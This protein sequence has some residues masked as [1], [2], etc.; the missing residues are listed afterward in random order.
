MNPPYEQDLASSVSS[1][2]SESVLRDL[3]KRVNREQFETWFRGF[4]VL[5]LDDAEV[6]VSVPNGFLRDWIARNYTDAVSKAV[7]VAKGDQR[8]RRVVVT[9]SVDG[10][11]TAD[12]FA[13]NRLPLDPVEEPTLVSPLSPAPSAPVPNASEMP[14]P[15]F[16]IAP[17]RSTRGTNPASGELSLNESY[18]F[19]EFVVGTSN[20]LAHA[21]AL[22]IGANPGR[23]F[24]PFFVQ[25]AVG[26]GKTHLLQAI[27]HAILRSHPRARV[28]YL[29]C[30][31]F[32]NRFIDSIQN[33]TISQFR[34]YHRSADVLVIDDVEFL[35]HKSQTQEEFFH[36]FNALYN[37]HKQIVL[38]S[39]CPPP[40]I[41][42][43]EA[44]LISRFKWGLETDITPPCFET[45]AAIV[46]RKARMRSIELPSDVVHYLAESVS[47]NIRELE[48][49]V[50]KV[51]G[52]A[53]ITGAP[54]TRA[55][56]EEALREGSV[57]RYRKITMADIMELITTEFSISARDLTSKSRTQAISLP[58]Q[59]G[60]F[61]ARN[62]TE[63]SLEEVGRFFGN[64][65]H[66]TVLYAVGKIKTRSETD[67]M[68]SELLG[69]LGQRLHSGNLERTPAGKA[70]RAAH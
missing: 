44:R 68:F 47:T 22:A 28:I 67:R 11:A 26:L 43:L 14:P 16:A 4:Q 70:R 62:Y 36:T 24:N 57:M 55:L 6:I 32:T 65:D 53:T 1:Q 8:Q 46:R 63:H 35:A 34:E 2:F 60:M 15:A 42:T 61:L 21:A 31:E 52:Q 3:R 25:G 50:I 41:P 39:D 38:S 27:C 49:A 40:Q 58:R 48:G 19:E 18:T 69:G 45:R 56:A 64:R 7:Q 12:S 20:R 9:T 54:I 37:A 59:I 5:R 29:S 13:P 66:T 51:I 17:D 33:R 23:A 30:E 10:T